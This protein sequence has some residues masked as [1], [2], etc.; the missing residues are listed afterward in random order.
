MVKIAIDP[1]RDE[2]K[3]EQAKGNGVMPNIAPTLEIAGLRAAR[4]GRVD[5]RMQDVVIGREFVV[6]GRI[7][8][9]T[10]AR[11]RFQQV[12][13]GVRFKH[14]GKWYK[15]TKDSES[16]LLDPSMPFADTC[17]VSVNIGIREWVN[18]L[19]WTLRGSVESERAAAGGA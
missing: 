8:Q 4:M 5:C 6:D 3:L 18:M 17:G 16:R 15:R 12:P 7:Y 19:E 9:S 1:R 2:P 11:V 14:D 10:T 13:V